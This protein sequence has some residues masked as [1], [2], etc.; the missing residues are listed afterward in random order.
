M[1]IEGYRDN[2]H[3]PWWVDISYSLSHPSTTLYLLY[4]VVLSCQNRPNR[5]TRRGICPIDQPEIHPGFVSHCGNV[6]RQI[7]IPRQIGGV[8]L[9]IFV[10]MLCWPPDVLGDFRVKCLDTTTT[11]P[12]VSARGIFPM[13]DSPS[14]YM[15]YMYKQLLPAVTPCRLIGIVGW[16]SKSWSFAGIDHCGYL[17]SI[18]CL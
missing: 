14:P 13:A 10:D 12:G 2:A 17:L 5:V 4:M 3:V 6:H 8:R 9:S 15:V 18:H 1:A 11:T 7:H 16:L